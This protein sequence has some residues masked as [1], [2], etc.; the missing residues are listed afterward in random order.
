[1]CENPAALV[2]A[3]SPEAAVICQAYEYHIFCVPV[4][5]LW[6]C[7][8]SRCHCSQG[9]WTTAAAVAGEKEWQINLPRRRDHVPL[10]PLTR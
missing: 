2:P 8:A 7:A 10:T 9:V 6:I 4:A 1:M 3:N 5:M